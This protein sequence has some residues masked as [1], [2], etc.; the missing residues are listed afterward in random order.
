ML[1]AISPVA[2]E[3]SYMQLIIVLVSA[4]LIVNSIVLAGLSY[5]KDKMEAVERMT[6]DW[7]TLVDCLVIVAAGI[8]VNSA[9]GNSSMVYYGIVLFAFLLL[10]LLIPSP[11]SK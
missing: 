1:I 10:A 6:K 9:T 8:F 2:P 5:K 4:L 11:E 7:K 3:D